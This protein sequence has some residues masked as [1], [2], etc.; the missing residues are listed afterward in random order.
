MTHATQRE[1]LNDIREAAFFSITADGTTR[2]VLPE[3]DTLINTLSPTEFYLGMYN[4]PM[5]L[6]SLCLRLLWT[7]C[8][9]LILE[10]SI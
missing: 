9:H 6:L 3:S 1:L 7:R 2:T 8:V 4:L 5:P 10:L